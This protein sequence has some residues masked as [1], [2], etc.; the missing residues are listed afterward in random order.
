LRG[1]WSISEGLKYEKGTVLD[2]HPERKK[3]Q[4][5]SLS[6]AA[7]GRKS[8]LK[9]FAEVASYPNVFE[10]SPGEEGM[11][12]N[13]EGTFRSMQGVWNLEFFREVQPLILELAC[14]KGEYTLALSRDRPDQNFIGVDIKGA[15]IWKGARLALA[16]NR[17]NVAFLRTR[18]EFIDRFF[19]PG[20]VDEIWITFPDPFEKKASRRLTAPGFLDRYRQILKPGGLMHLKTDSWLLYEYTLDVIHHDPRCQLLYAN[21]DIYARDLIFPELEHKT[22]YEGHHLADGRLIKYVR[23][24]I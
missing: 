22:Y 10:A 4:G 3:D 24:T 2:E 6:F 18:I 11:L 7:M 16:E 23:F 1:L 5:V 12:S 21:P 20:E 19:E 14:G 13:E 9:R 8:K 17:T 15:R